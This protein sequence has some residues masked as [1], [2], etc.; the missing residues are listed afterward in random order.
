[1]MT[2]KKL[3]TDWR[4]V[5]TGLI[6]ITALEIVAL[7]KGINGMVLSTVI[8]IIALAIGVTINNPLKLKRQL[9][10]GVK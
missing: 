8:G 9:K 7:S 6:C 10:G 3:K 5:A 1:M 4:I 2:T